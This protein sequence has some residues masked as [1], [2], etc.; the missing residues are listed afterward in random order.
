MPYTLHTPSSLSTL[1]L[2]LSPLTSPI[3]S[4]PTG[5]HL[6]P[7]PEDKRDGEVV[8]DEDDVSKA[9]PGALGYVQ[10]PLSREAREIGGSV[11]VYY[12]VRHTVVSRAAGGAGMEVAEAVSTK[13][14]EKGKVALGSRKEWRWWGTKGKEKGRE[15]AD[16][17][18]AETE[19]QGFELGLGLPSFEGEVGWQEIRVEVAASEF[20]SSSQY[21]L[22]LLEPPVL[23]SLYL[24]SFSQLI[25]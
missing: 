15:T 5:L 6:K 2:P 24:H 8:E 23:T 7:L 14:R 20:A 19:M 16:D 10:L 21:S 3:A 13:G 18:D 17:N 25:P 12:V 4:P 22:Y 9:V 11:E 1:T